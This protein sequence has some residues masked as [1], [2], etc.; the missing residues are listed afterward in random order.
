MFSVIFKTEKL[1]PV[2]TVSKIIYE[3]KQILI[4]D[5]A[6]ISNKN[7][8]FAGENLTEPDADRLIS[9]C[10]KNGIE[11]MKVENE[12][13]KKFNNPT[14]ITN[15]S[16]E[17]QNLNYK[18]NDAISSHKLE[19]ISVLACAQIEY[20]VSK[21]ITTKEGPSA[22]E[23][24]IRIGIMMTTGLPIGTGKG[25]EVK[26]E[27]KNTETTSYLDIVFIN[28]VHLRINSDHFDYSCLKEKKTYS[29]N[30]N[31]KLLSAQISS[32]CPKALKNSPLFDLIE[33]KPLSIRYES[34]TDME[35]DL[36][37]LVYLRSA[38]IL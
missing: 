28:E 22:G 18:L 35:K 1:P 2:Q 4:Y 15:L 21:T 7:Y 17:N 36:S 8:G 34:I 33:N 32:L 30:M 16:F 31:F 10:S 14:T 6:R 13:I 23:K 27:I 29:T 12:K 38:R 19:D 24:A 3:F 9:I 25:K 26:K 11:A 20:N 37:R 5:A